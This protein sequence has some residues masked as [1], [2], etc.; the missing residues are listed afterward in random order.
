MATI[1]VSSGEK[2]LFKDFQD[3]NT[4][5]FRVSVSPGGD[6]EYCKGTR[7]KVVCGDESSDGKIVSDPLVV[8]PS[9]DG[10]EETISLVVEKG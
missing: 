3:G 5:Q 2:T 7:V 9:K 1:N 10:G 8:T 4:V 6:K